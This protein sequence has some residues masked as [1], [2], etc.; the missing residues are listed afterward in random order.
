MRVV[1]PDEAAAVPLDHQRFVFNGTVHRLTHEVAQGREVLLVVGGRYSVEGWA[2]RQGFRN[3]TVGRYLGSSD[4]QPA[5]P[6]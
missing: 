5:R 1:T 3:I 4:P 2:R 6:R